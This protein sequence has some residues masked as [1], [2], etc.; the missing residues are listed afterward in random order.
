MHGSLEPYFSD[1]YMTV[2]HKRATFSRLG[3]VGAKWL[4]Y[5]LS[6]SIK[7]T[8]DGVFQAIKI[9]SSYRLTQS[10]KHNGN[11]CEAI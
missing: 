4:N 8:Q 9:V 10:Q 6:Y 3:A 11:I 2:Y 5:G 1:T 7:P